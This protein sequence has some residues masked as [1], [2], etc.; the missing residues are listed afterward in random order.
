M[1]TLTNQLDCWLCHYLN[2]TR[3]PE[4]SFVPASASTWQTHSGHFTSSY[5]RVIW[6]WGTPVEAQVL[7]FTQMAPSN[8]LQGVVSQMVEEGV[9]VEVRWKLI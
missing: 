1:A 4:L 9:P 2:N 3:E 7:S 5:S 6:H 8:L